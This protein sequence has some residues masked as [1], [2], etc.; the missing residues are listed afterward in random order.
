VIRATKTAC[1]TGAEPPTFAT[2]SV[3]IEEAW[4]LGLGRKRSQA[5]LARPDEDAVLG[6]LARQRRETKKRVGV[7]DT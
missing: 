3:S 2:V 5:Q 1:E 6:G 4:D 7:G